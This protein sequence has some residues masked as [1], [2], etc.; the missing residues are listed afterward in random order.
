VPAKDAGK[1]APLLW[2]GL[3]AASEQ[4]APEGVQLRPRPF[5]VG[6]ALEL[7]TPAPGLPANVREAEKSERLRLAQAPLLTLLGGEPPE[8][9]Q[10]RL[11]GV[12]LQTEPREPV[13]KI[14][15]EPL[16]ITTMLETH[17]EVIS[18]T[19]DDNVTVRVPSPPLMSPQ[20]ED[21]VE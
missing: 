17:H 14:R 3:I 13:A 19:R 4:L 10:P 18:K 2:N 9:D 15:P 6:D 12:Q 1:P 21:V 7:K 11:L 5:R 20:I 8:P 16:G